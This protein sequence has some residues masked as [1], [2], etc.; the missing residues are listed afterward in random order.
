MKKIGVACDHAG[1]QMKELIIGYLDAMGYEA[2]DFGCYSEE[3]C[4]FPDMAHPLAYAVEKGEV[5]FGIALCGS[6]NGITMT[7]NKHQGIRAA[8]CWEPELAILAKEHNNANICSLPARYIDNSVAIEV[9]EAFLNTPFSGEERH[10]R[11]N[12]KIAIAK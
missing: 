3:S 2:F 10:A 4:D 11:R 5:N 1:Y 7:L 9:V 8:I 12:A 6:A